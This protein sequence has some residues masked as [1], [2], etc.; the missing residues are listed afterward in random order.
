MRDP[1]SPIIEARSAR[2]MTGEVGRRR[3]PG[4][5]AH[6]M[7]I[8]HHEPRSEVR[9]DHGIDVIPP[10]RSRA[11]HMSLMDLRHDSAILNGHAQTV[12]KREGRVG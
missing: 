1:I 2:V 4:E 5:G 8:T 3:G 7:A 12:V 10:G 11:M 6:I 9:R